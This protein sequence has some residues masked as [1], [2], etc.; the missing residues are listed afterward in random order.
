MKQKTFL[1]SIAIAVILFGCKNEP[2]EQDNSINTDQ[3]ELNRINPLE[4][5]KQV[6]HL[7]SEIAEKPQKLTAPSD[8]PTTITGAKGTVIYVDPDRLETMDGS[9]IG[10]KIEIELLEMTNNSS[11]LLNNIQTVSNGELIVTGGAYYLNMTSDGNQLR[12]REGTGLRVEFPKLT[13]DEMELFLGERDS[14]GQINWTPTNDTFKPKDTEVA[15]NNEPKNSAEPTK[16]IK[17]SKNDNRVIAV[18]FEDSL[19]YELQ[20]Y[21]NVKFRV[22]DD[23]EFNPEDHNKN[24]YN[25]DISKSQVPGEYIIVFEGYS[26]KGQRIKR[27]YEVTPVFE[28]E[29]HDIAMKQ[30]EDKYNEHLRR[31]AEVELQRQTYEAVE[32]MEFG[33]KN[34]DILLNDPNPR[35]EIQLLV[36]NKSFLG[37]RMYAVFTDINVILTEKYWMGRQ[38]TAAFRNIPTGREML[39][40][41]LSAKDETPYYFETTINTETDRQVNV[42]FGATTQEDIIEKMKQMN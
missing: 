26:E 27:K 14:L 18:V 10:E 41:A 39:I 25:V 13:D 35:T 16:P 31:K 38:D 2:A 33:W 40:I 37:A 8:K 30:Y 5:L 15:I 24:W 23:C 3:V 12:M 36:N 6:D 19:M 32:L 22:N 17:A 21:H 7:L 20:H 29:D 34:V 9:P 42:N 11:M 1:I 4:Q 28:G